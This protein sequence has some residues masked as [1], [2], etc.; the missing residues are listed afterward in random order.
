MKIS[1]SM[2]YDRKTAMSKITELS[3]ELAEH[4]LKVAAMP[5][6]KYAEGWLKEISAWLARA[7]LYA[8]LTKG[9]HLKPNDFK[10]SILGGCDFHPLKSLW[11]SEL[12][13][14]YPEAVLTDEQV[15]KIVKLADTLATLLSRP[16][17]SYKWK[18]LVREAL[19]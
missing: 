8:N 12:E 13:D 17:Q 2:A 10:I 7:Y 14:E 18:D 16:K 5:G 15:G 3:F 6:S 9:K 1:L 11:A 4:M 19:K